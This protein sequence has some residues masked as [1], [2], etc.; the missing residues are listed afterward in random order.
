MQ[1]NDR[2]KSIL[3]AVVDDYVS[4]AEPVGSKALVSKFHFAVSS[5]TVRNEMAEL[6]ELGYLEQP[7]TSAGRIPSDKGYRA[8][9]DD[10]MQ[11]EDLPEDETAK[12]R[13]YFRDSMDE[14]TGLIRKASS[15][16]SDRTGYASLALAPQM[17]RSHLKQIKM[18]MI[19]PGKALVVVVLSA[20]IV[21]DRLVR[22]PE[23]LDAAQLLQISTA[24]EEGLSG[25]KLDDIT[26][27][28]VFSA[29]R[30]ALLPDSLL[31]QVLYEAYIAI[32]QADHLEIYIDGTNKLLSY[33]EFHD[34]HKAREYLDTLARDGM[35]A[36]YMS[37]MKDQDAVLQPVQSKG[38]QDLAEA[39]EGVQ[40]F[41]GTNPAGQ[42]RQ[43]YM[44]RI[45][46]EIMLDGLKDCSF[47][48]T[49]Y[50][51]GDVIAGRIGIIGPRRMAYG[52]VIS[53]ISFVRQSIN[54]QFK[55]L[56]RSGDKR[57]DLET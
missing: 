33:P 17:R 31:N 7:H 48:T 39:A 57:E 32:K 27:V 14:L 49:T 46:Q 25:M 8:Y 45:G 10:L 4:T 47:V 6:E 56:A 52:K 3:K 26:L 12:I 13:D 50:K 11:V 29:A 9:V 22:I 19:E 21:K 5:A 24:I 55:R 44:I 20:G 34:I 1:L 36:G 28:T 51:L 30:N 35:I 40:G 41:P 53:N 23:L 18:L 15:L 38:M 16:L 54:E 37:E 2:K 43:S 42:D